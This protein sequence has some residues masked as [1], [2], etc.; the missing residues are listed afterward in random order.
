MI[1]FLISTFQVI[2]SLCSNG[3]NAVTFP[4]IAQALS[5]FP[6]PGVVD[7]KLLS[8]IKTWMLSETSTFPAELKMASFHLL[9]KI[10]TNCMSKDEI[11]LVEFIK[12]AKVI[13]EH[14][15]LTPG[16][17]LWCQFISKL[18]KNVFSWKLENGVVPRIENFE[19]FNEICHSAVVEFLNGNNKVF[20]RT[21]EV[22]LIMLVTIDLSM[23]NEKETSTELVERIL[24]PVLETLTKFGRNPYISEEQV[25]RAVSLVNF[26][27]IG[28]IESKKHSHKNLSFLN[29]LDKLL[30]MVKPIF[31]MYRTILHM[32]CNEE[33]MNFDLTKLCYNLN[34]LIFNYIPSTPEL[35]TSH[36]QLIIEHVEFLLKFCSHHLNDIAAGNGKQKHAYLIFKSLEMICNM[37]NGKSNEFIRNA[38]L[39]FANIFLEIIININLDFSIFLPKPNDR[40]E[41]DALEVT[42]FDVG[43][44]TKSL[45]SLVSFAVSKDEIQSAIASRANVDNKHPGSLLSHP[46]NLPLTLS[47][48][49]VS[50]LVNI[51]LETID[52]SV[53]TDMIPLLQCLAS[54]MPN[55]VTSPLNLSVG[56]LKSVWRLLKE[57]ERRDSR[58]WKIF[59]PCVNVLFHKSVML[60][61][62]TELLDMVTEFWRFLEDV[63]QKKSGLLN[64]VVGH[65]CAILEEWF[66]ERS[67]VMNKPNCSTKEQCNSMLWC[68]N[69]LVDACT[70]G[71][72]Q[73]K[74]ARIMQQVIKYF[75]AQQLNA[76]KVSKNV[77]IDYQVRWIVVKM[78]LKIDD[79]SEQSYVAEEVMKRL[80][81]K[82]RKISE[83]VKR[84]YDNSITHRQKLR[85]W[86]TMLTLNKFVN[87]G[88]AMEI[89]S[90]ALSVM[91]SENQPSIRYYIEWFVVI[92]ISKMPS[93]KSII[94]EKLSE[95]S[96]RRVCSVTCLMSIIMHVAVVLPDGEFSEMA[97]EAFAKILP[98]VQIHHMQARVHAQIV[99]WKLW[100]EL[101]FRGCDH[102]LQEYQIIE[103]LFTLN[104]TNASVFKA[105]EEIRNHFYFKTFHP[106]EHFSLETIFCSMPKLLNVG[107]DEL[108]DDNQLI[109]MLGN[110]DDFYGKKVLNKGQSLFDLVTKMGHRSEKRVTEME[111]KTTVAED[112]SKG[113]YIK[114]I[115]TL[116]CKDFY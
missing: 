96:E 4:Y 7:S 56:V 106:I 70:F 88:N 72:V 54:L 39:Q 28:C 50:D 22:G 8:L 74:A 15:Y 53:G 91:V 79:K 46:D 77:N 31:S 35:T 42:S 111:T 61:A 47:T 59:T 21:E 65:C 19:S 99:I 109:E 17:E 107:D 18:Q 66:V 114:L 57:Q 116:L 29:I 6:F 27:L 90:G 110:K 60:S 71:H 75:N 32:G 78:L 41:K 87:E 64:V 92:I 94:W 55:I 58:F 103:S 26:L 48:C 1:E 30:G 2:E 13:Y 20:E 14:G 86:Q 83:Q 5:T 43:D 108:L 12:F 93:F 102:V 84:Y 36:G 45:W 68:I 115:C 9:L 112:C 52:V 73:K 62:N 24:N 76:K 95:A 11:T 33:S 69:L 37:L 98:W 38:R 10:V 40:K 89:L 100:D 16:S 105:R 97:A 51:I 101:K 3:Y 23:K 25:Q 81:E 63:G 44:I 82:D 104:E 80:I 34:S 113:N 49:S 67:N 85:I